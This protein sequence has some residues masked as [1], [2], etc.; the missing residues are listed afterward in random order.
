MV[1]IKTL[2][3]K[4]GKKQTAVTAPCF[5]PISCDIDMSFFYYEF[6]LKS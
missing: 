1:L 3:H 2:F 6:D 4:G 5:V